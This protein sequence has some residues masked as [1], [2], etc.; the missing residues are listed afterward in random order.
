MSDE[1]REGYAD[2]VV[3]VRE[4]KDEVEGQRADYVDV[5]QIVAGLKEGAEERK[6]QVA[7]L[8]RLV[9]DHVATKDDVTRM[10]EELKHHGGEDDKRFAETRTESRTAFADVM[11]ILRGDEDTPGIAQRVKSMETDR[12]MLRRNLWTILGAAVGV[13]T[14]VAGC[15]EVWQFMRGH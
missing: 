14:F 13:P 9:R 11:K 3:L 2:L 10:L 6:G 8:F 15:I 12:A 5:V 4:L 1:R 7:E